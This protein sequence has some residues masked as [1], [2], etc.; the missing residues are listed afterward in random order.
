MNVKET[1][2]VRGGLRDT[3][4]ALTNG[5]KSAELINKLMNEADEAP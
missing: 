1:R 5:K 4:S 3:N 2:S